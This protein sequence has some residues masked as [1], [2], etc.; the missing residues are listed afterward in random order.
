MKKIIKIE[1]MHC[2][3]CQS[4]A[5]KALNAIPG[6]EAKVNLGRKEAVAILTADVDDQVFRDAL[7]EI[8]YK[9]ISISAQ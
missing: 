7:N 1:G 3:H 5:E 8:G 2:A 4:S 9:A 6:V